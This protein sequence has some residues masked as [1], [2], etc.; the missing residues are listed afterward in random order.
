[1]DNMKKRPHSYPK[2]TL[3]LLRYM[4]MISVGTWLCRNT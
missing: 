3:T 2:L 1:M 4:A